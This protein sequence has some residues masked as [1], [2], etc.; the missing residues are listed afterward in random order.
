MDCH[1]KEG[2]AIIISRTDTAKWKRQAPGS[3]SR[4]RTPPQL[5]KPLPLLP[6]P[7]SLQEITGNKWPRLSRRFSS[8]GHFTLL[9]ILLLIFFFFR[10]T[11]EFLQIIMTA[12][13][14]DTEYGIRNTV[15]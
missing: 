6:T 3:V 5:Q 14:P 1:E 2:R 4:L 9:F 15:E 11:S 10:S 8:C 12:P 7:L 13:G